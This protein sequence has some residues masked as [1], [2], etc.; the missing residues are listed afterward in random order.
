[1]VPDADNMVDYHVS[2]GG[3]IAGLDNGREE[4]AEGYKGTA[5]TVFN[6][7]GL[8]IVQSN[9]DPGPIRITAAAT[10]LRRATATLL[11]SGHH[12][13]ETIHPQPPAATPPVDAVPQSGWPRADASY[14]GAP[15]TVPQ[16]MLDGNTSSGGWSNYYNKVATALLPSFSI[17]HASEWVSVAWPEERTLGSLT[18]YFTTDAKHELPATIAVSYWDGQRFVPA[19]GVHVD[20]AGASNQPTT[21]AFDSVRTSAIRLEMTSR[22]PGT[23]HGF[24]QIAELQFPG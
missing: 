20:W 12:G 10:G 13:A 9:G 24:L 14:S 3:F 22:D 17:A 1:V 16:A 18:A 8:A 21:I 5:H 6:G 7:K 15:A 2:G 19:T 11:A 23:D 4:D